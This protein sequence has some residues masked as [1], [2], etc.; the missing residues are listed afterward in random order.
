MIRPDKAYD[1]EILM[2]RVD[3]ELTPD[4]GAAIDAA[5]TSDA[6]LAERLATMRR[7][8]GAAREAFPAT[9]DARDADLARMIRVGEAAK[10]LPFGGLAQAVRE[11]FAPRRAAIWGGLATAA[12]VGGLVVGPMLGV[13]NQGLSVE[14]DGTIADA[15]LTR[16]LDMRLASD[17]ADGAGRAVGL[18]FR[19]AEGNWCR[20]FQARND[21]VAGLACR[22]DDGWAWKALAPL[23]GSTTEFRQAASDTPGV[24]LSAVD[25][26]IAGDTLDAATEAQARDAGWR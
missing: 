8:R 16:V 11:A 12:F 5:A 26:T 22:Q 15:A 23:T 2:R 1:D 19:D 6:V 25:A 18:T 9:P 17:G 20:T 3:G 4:Q 21:G 10:A 14:P 13:R 7:L 24:V